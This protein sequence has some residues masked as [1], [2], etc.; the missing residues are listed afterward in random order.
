MKAVTEQLTQQIAEVLRK[1]AVSIP[2]D[3]GTMR[4]SCGGWTNRWGQR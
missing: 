3:G 2:A 4:C 1:H